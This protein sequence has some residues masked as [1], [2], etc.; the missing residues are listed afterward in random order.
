MHVKDPVVHVRVRWIMETLKHTAYTVDWVAPLAAGF[1]WGKQPGFPKREI[2]MG[3]YN[4][5]KKKKNLSV[6]TNTTQAILN[7]SEM[8]EHNKYTC[9]QFCFS[10]L[11]PEARKRHPLEPILFLGTPKQEPISVA[12][13]HA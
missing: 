2:P 4:W 5:K 8:I 12:C 1:P 10:Y 3:Q 9:M 6:N 13:G 11:S 7:Q